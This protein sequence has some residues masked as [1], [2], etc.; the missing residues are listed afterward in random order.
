MRAVRSAS[1]GGR[2]VEI[3]PLRVDG[4]F[5]RFGE[6]HE[7]VRYTDIGADTVTVRAEDGATATVAVPFPPLAA[8]AG[9]HPGVAVADLVAHLVVPRRIGLLLVRL[10]GHS[11]GVAEGGRV[12]LSTT[13]RNQVHGRNKA[14]GWSQQRFA[15]RRAGQVRQSL[16]STA[17]DT[18]RVLVPRLPELVAV[19]L[20]GDRHA[21]D[22]LR[23]DR[24]LAGVFAL[25]T[26]RVLDVPEPRRTV[27]DEA[28][29]RAM[30]VE[31]LVTEP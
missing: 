4:W 9:R 27:L 30:A 28:A 24:R 16:R 23:E 20:G 22:A 26:D 2:Y 29:E 8:P 18:V 6:R 10:G 12:L 15:R 17:D 13:D 11:I 14:G 5:A 1:G 31:I 25:A 3:S 19:V 7:G 21:L